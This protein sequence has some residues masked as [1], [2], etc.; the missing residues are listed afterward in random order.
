MTSNAG[1]LKI[2]LS[3]PDITEAEIRAVERVL[4]GGL[5]PGARRRDREVV[6]DVGAHPGHL[7][8]PGGM[9]LAMRDSQVSPQHLLSLPVL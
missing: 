3:A 9:G 1:E 7:D 2:P 5:L 8:V 4:R 6:A